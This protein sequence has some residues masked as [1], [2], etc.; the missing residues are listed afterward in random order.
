MAVVSRRKRNGQENRCRQGQE[1][2]TDGSG[3]PDRQ[4]QHKIQNHARETPAFQAKIPKISSGGNLPPRIQIIFNKH[5][6]PTHHPRD[7]SVSAASKAVIA[8]RWR[9]KPHFAQFDMFPRSPWRQIAAATEYYISLI[10][11]IINGERP[12]PSAFGG[13]LPQRGRLLLH[14]CVPSVPLS[15]APTCFFFAR[16]RPVS[17]SHAPTCFF[18]ARS[19]PFRLSPGAVHFAFRMMTKPQTIRAINCTMPP[20]A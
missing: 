1:G 9:R 16:L 13:H 3:R 10:S 11:T 5:R 20:S 12:H 6:V 18:F 7:H 17:S 8:F 15:H 14:R 2:P 4:R 19:G